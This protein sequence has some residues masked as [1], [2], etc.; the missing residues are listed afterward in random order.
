MML[1]SL[2][3]Y[4]YATDFGSR[5][6]LFNEHVGSTTIISATWQTIGYNGSVST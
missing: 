1:E 5:R 4:V 2:E 3:S 6:F